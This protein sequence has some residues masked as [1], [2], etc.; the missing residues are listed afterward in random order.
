MNGRERVERGEEVERREGGVEGKDEGEKER[1]ERKEEGGGG[2]QAT[3]FYEPDLVP[4]AHFHRL[5]SLSPPRNLPG[6]K[7]QK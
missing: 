7:A 6:Y 1:R 4:K 2:A 5:L 3:I